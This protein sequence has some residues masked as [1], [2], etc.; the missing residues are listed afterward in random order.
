MNVR[1][2]VWFSLGIVFLGVAYLGVIVPGLPWSTPAVIAAYCFAK[3]SDRMHRWIYSHRI[4]GPFLLGWQEKRIFPTKFK[5]F[6]IV[7]M[8]S[9]LTIMWFTTGNLTAIAW[10]SAFMLAVVVWGWRYPGSE[11]EWQRR[12][13]A[14][15]RIAWLS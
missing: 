7:T 2:I 8:L 10:T 13:D 11:T 5:Y 12:K 3:S 14:G 15:E 4:F 6:M 1:K 9:S